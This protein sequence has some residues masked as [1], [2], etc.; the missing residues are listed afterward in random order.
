MEGALA[1]LS[2]ANLSPPTTSPS[3]AVVAAATPSPAWRRPCR[4]RPP[5]RWP[6]RRRR[7]SR[8]A[9]GGPA[10]GR[11]LKKSIKWFL[12]ELVCL[13]AAAILPLS[14]EPAGC[15]SSREQNRSTED[16]LSCTSMYQYVLVWKESHTGIYRFVPLC[17]CINREIPIACTV[18]YRHVP[19]CTY[20]YRDI[21]FWYIPVHTSM[22]GYLL[23]RKVHGGSY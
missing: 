23:L 19:L 9:G 1:R 3:L 2:N 10:Q 15:C 12:F 13:S 17:T 4:P 16:V 5:R 14:R 21:P 6:S 22:Y 7:P 20:I 18:I 11:C 8:C